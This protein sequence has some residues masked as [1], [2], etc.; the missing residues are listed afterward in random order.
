[1]DD[2]LRQFVNQRGG[3][4]CE[5][6]KIHRD[7][8]P[9]YQFHIEH[10]QARQH[11]GPTVASNLALACQHCNLHKGPNLSGID[12]AT[13]AV[14]QLF[15]PR[16]Q[17]WSEHFTIRNGVVVGL[18]ATGRA[19]VRVLAMNVTARVRIRASSVAL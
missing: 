8:D 16:Q 13:N 14:V 5:Y 3:D 19:T 4:R 15:N 7:H 2:S 11:G 12:P 9:F 18:T 1:L 17:T 10:I 6:C